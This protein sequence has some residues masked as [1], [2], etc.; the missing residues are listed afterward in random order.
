[1]RHAV[2]SIG[3]NTFYDFPSISSVTCRCPRLGAI[4]P[5]FAYFFLNYRPTVV[6]HYQKYEIDFFCSICLMKINFL[7]TL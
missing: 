7:S 4:G 3:Y 2:S 6:P 5:I 1:M